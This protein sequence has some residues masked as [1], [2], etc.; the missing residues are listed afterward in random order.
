MD[1]NQNTNGGGRSN[2]EVGHAKNVAQL[3]KLITLCEL[4]G[5]EYNP[6]NSLIKMVELKKFYQTSDDKITLVHQAVGVE[7]VAINERQIIFQ[8]LDSVATRTVNILEVISNEKKIVADARTILRKIRGEA[9][10][11][12][13]KENQEGQETQKPK[14]NSQ[15]S[16]DK[17]IDHFTALIELIKQ[18][19]DYEPNETELTIAGLEVFRADLVMKNKNFINANAQ[20]KKARINRNKKLYDPTEG[21]INR[22]KLVK[23]YVKS[24]YGASSPQYKDI[25]AIKFR[26]LK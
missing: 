7:D 3:Q 10:R 8:K 17:L 16:Y 1:T 21:L 15:Q 26:T 25:N 20:V 19:P 13:T 23:I 6:P 5:A 11:P 24:L 9:P 12:K 4:L 22:A 14:S 18:V 2:S